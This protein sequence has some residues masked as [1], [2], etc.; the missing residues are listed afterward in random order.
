MIRLCVCVVALGGVIAF[1]S[2]SSHPGN[3]ISD[4][5]GD[6]K[7]PTGG[8]PGSG[9]HGSSGGSDGR[10]PVGSGGHGTGG[11]WST[12]DGSAPIGTGGRGVGGINWGDGS[13]P[14]G[15]GGRGIGGITDGSG[16][17][18]TGGRGVGGINWGDGAGPI[19]GKGGA[20]GAQPC[21]GLP[22]FEQAGLCASALSSQVGKIPSGYCD[23]VTVLRGTCENEQ[24]WT[25]KYKAL[26]DPVLCAYDTTGKLVA[27]R[28]C[29]DTP[30]WNCNGA[31]QASAC[32]SAG[33]VPDTSRC[34][35]N[36]ACANQSDGSGPVGGHA[37][38]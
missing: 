24:V 18:G 2:C 23:T 20:G 35:L 8:T 27:A 30:K 3:P 29:T 16:P 1:L 14:I 5:G 28:V 25:T 10:G 32:L 21:D 7:G 26:G 9:G 22:Y 33:T 13:A 4:G 17:I 6:G 19:G 34:S 15:T 12:G 36:D 31:A 37:G 38:H 11:F